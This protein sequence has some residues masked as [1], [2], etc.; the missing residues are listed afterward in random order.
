[1][2]V[3]QLGSNNRYFYFST[4]QTMTEA[5]SQTYTNQYRVWVDS[6][7]YSNGNTIATVKACWFGSRTPGTGTT[8]Y[9]YLGRWRDAVAGT[10]PDTGKACPYMAQSYIDAA[11]GAT[12]YYKPN[13]FFQASNIIFEIDIGTGNGG[14]ANAKTKSITISGYQ[15]AASIYEMTKY[16]NSSACVP[17]DNNWP[18]S[19]TGSWQW[20]TG[21]TA[22]PAITCGQAFGPTTDGAALLG[23]VGHRWKQLYAATTTIYTSARMR[24]TDI[25]E[26]PDEYDLFFD[27]LKPSTF[28]FK[29]ELDGKKHTGFIL[30]EVADALRYADIPKEEFAGYV[31][32]DKRDELADGGLRY[33]EFIAINTDQI[34]KLKKRVSEL[35]ALVEELERARNE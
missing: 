22:R 10:N 5:T 32:F 24:K 21:D 29:E 23:G 4:S 34:Q 26:M 1:M 20:S 28:R 15:G 25:I 3:N 17:N 12:N 30:D 8:V 14:E 13:N 33:S 6:V 16:G 11:G 9:F 27:K 2:T 18:N 31:T 7:T 19:D 35:E